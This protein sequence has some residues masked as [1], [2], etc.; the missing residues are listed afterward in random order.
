[1]STAPHSCLGQ[2]DTLPTYLYHLLHKHHYEPLAAIKG[3]VSRG[4]IF[5]KMLCYVHI[6]MHVFKNRKLKIL[7]VLFFSFRIQI[8][9]TWNSYPT[10]QEKYFE[11][12][13]K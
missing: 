11:K 4:S 13:K 3:R 5:L 10:Y 2:L 6:I 7:C 12:K 1:L 9:K 8:E